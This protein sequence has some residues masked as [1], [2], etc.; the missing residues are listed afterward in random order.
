MLGL[1]MRK[2]SIPLHTWSRRST[3]GHFRVLEDIL[4]PNRVYCKVSKDIVLTGTELGATEETKKE[5]VECVR[6]LQA[7]S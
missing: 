1:L 2:D 6:A 5:K 7:L 4:A 3:K